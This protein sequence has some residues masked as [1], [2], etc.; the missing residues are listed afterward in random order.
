MDTEEQGNGSGETNERREF[1]RLPISMPLRFL[2]PKTNEGKETQTHDI[3]A[4]GVCIWADQELPANVTLEM[5]LEI[6]GDGQVRYNKGK[7]IWSKEVE[8]NRY[9]VGIGL[10]KVDLIGV[11]LILRAVDG[12]KWL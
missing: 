7:V 11:S 3:C 12:P 6:P 4:K 2:D 10:E 1:V 9:K 5:W 8:A